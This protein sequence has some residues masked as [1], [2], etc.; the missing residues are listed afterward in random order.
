MKRLL[1][2]SLTLFITAGM[3]LPVVTA[4]AE[5]MYIKPSVEIP[6]RRGQGIDYKILAMLS[7]GQ[8]ATLLETNNSWARISLEN[9][10]EGWIPKRYLTEEKPLTETMKKLAAENKKLSEELEKL[11][12]ENNQ[13]ANLNE[14]LAAT[15]TQ[16]KDELSKVLDENSAA[17]QSAA[18]IAALNTRLAKSE[19]AAAALQQQLAAAKETNRK[20]QTN[21]GVAWFLAGA[22]TFLIAFL[23]GLSKRKT[24]KS[25]LY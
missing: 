16:K 20:I 7:E 8:T 21:K 14:Q 4:A 17:H 2:L 10:K 6:L 24:K 22:G 3:V 1:S 5:T 19:K 18:K 12:Q 15:L 13:Q 9:G 11:K 25:R 23:L